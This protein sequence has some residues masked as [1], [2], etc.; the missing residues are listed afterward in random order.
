MLLTAAVL[1]GLGLIVPFSITWDKY[2]IFERA[3]LHLDGFIFK[4]NSF[5]RVMMFSTSIFMLLQRLAVQNYVI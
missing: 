1:A 4:L 3:N 5:S 2:S